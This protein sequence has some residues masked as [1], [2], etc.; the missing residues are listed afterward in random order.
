[1]Q[2]WLPQA[3]SGFEPIVHLHLK[4]RFRCGLGANQGAHCQCDRKMSNINKRKKLF[5]CSFVD[6]K[7]ERCFNTGCWRKCCRRKNSFYGG[8]HPCG[9][10]ESACTL[11]YIYEDE[12]LSDGYRL[13]KRTSEEG[14]KVQSQTNWRVGDFVWVPA[15][16]QV[17]PL[18]PK[19]RAKR[20]REAEQDEV[21]V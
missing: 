15:N 8:S 18:A 11:T 14:R 13:V 2:A 19:T 7:D 17:L 16:P 10:P 12:A 6:C 9:A 4:V 21:T 5:F 20:S 1:M 3:K